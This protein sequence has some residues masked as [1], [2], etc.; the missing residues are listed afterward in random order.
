MKFL[1]FLIISILVTSVPVSA[2]APPPPTSV[3]DIDVTGSERYKEFTIPL[4]AYHTHDP[5]AWLS[6]SKD[7]NLLPHFAYGDDIYM[8]STIIADVTNENFF[9]IEGGTV[10]F[11]YYFANHA[12]DNI[13]IRKIFIDVVDDFEIGY[14]LYNEDLI[15]LDTS[16]YD[17]LGDED[18]QFT[19]LD[20]TV[21]KPSLDLTLLPQITKESVES[22]TSTERI[23]A[24]YIEYVKENVV[25]DSMDLGEGVYHLTYH[26]YYNDY[27]PDIVDYETIE[28]NIDY[29]LKNEPREMVEATN[30]RQEPLGTFNINLPQSNSSKGSIKLSTILIILGIGCFF[31]SVVVYLR[32]KFHT[33]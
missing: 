26:R 31:I 30:Y 13:K 22:S 11:S 4:D 21:E 23:N 3:M 18:L 24:I 29:I 12:Y 32:K 6:V 5:I 19:F 25:F 8:D 1:T 14:L 15:S 7:G 2:E 17:F 9:D 20:A 33:A 10:D 28:N 27:Y 16:N